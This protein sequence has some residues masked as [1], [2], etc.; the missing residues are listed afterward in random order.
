MIMKE[1]VYTEIAAVSP[2]ASQVRRVSWGAIFAGL[3]VTIVIQ[4]T[5]TLLGVAIGAA[6]IDPLRERNPTEG[7]S[8]AS[9]IWLTVS[10]L[11]SMWIGALVA[12]RLCGGPRRADGLIHGIVTWSASTITMLLLLAST[13]G[14]VLGGAG[15]LI[16]R[17]VNVSL[18]GGQNP[19]AAIQNQIRQ[20]LPQASQALPPTGREQGAAVPQVNEQQAREAGDAAARGVSQAALWGFI[21]LI[22]EL[23]L[24]AWGGWVG[25]ATLR[26][27]VEQRA[28]TS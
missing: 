15:A 20:N 1:E 8:A 27:Y 2:A 25:T 10:A 23:G 16:G 7:L 21:A 4:L 6:T 11:I 26:R 13:A 24:A 9:A 14:A 19:F 18:Q 28:V 17:T 22:L 12:G 3:V 5:L